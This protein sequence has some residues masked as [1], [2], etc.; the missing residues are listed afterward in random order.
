MISADPVAVVMP[1]AF[2]FVGEAAVNVMDEGVNRPAK[3]SRVFGVDTSVV[4]TSSRRIGCNRGAA[5]GESGVSGV[6]ILGGSRA[7]LVCDQPS[8]DTL[9]RAFSVFWSA[10]GT[11]GASA[12]L[13]DIRVKL[14]SSRGLV[15]RGTAEKNCL[16]DA[17]RVPLRRDWTRPDISR[18]FLFR[19]LKVSN[20]LAGRYVEVSRITYLARGCKFGFAKGREPVLWDPVQFVMNQ[21]P[22]SQARDTLRRR[23]WRNN[24]GCVRA[25]LRACW[26]TLVKGAIESLPRPDRRAH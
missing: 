2:T 23:W 24:P 25:T 4:L 14:G 11:L 22:N 3:G 15:G 5:G 10:E 7:G 18:C 8:F 17:G 9:G 6:E 20:R 19:H 12:A 16:L 21:L 26:E 13:K 1:A